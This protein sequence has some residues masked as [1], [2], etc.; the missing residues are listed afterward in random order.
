MK[1]T[2]KRTWRECKK[3]GHVW[4]S[5]ARLINIKV[6]PEC[7]SEHWNKSL[8]G[9]DFPPTIR[10]THKDWIKLGCPEMVKVTGGC[11]FIKK[12]RWPAETGILN[13]STEVI[14]LTNEQEIN[15]KIVDQSMLGCL[16]AG[17]VM[18][19]QGLVNDYEVGA[20]LVKLNDVP[21]YDAHIHLTLTRKVCAGNIS[22]ELKV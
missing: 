20:S 1:R 9:I 15:C 5:R 3:C 13:Q 7:G 8:F 10:L 16:L 22:V 18:K 12:G 21:E 6:C 4:Q 14:G 19:S 17:E 11:R 2:L